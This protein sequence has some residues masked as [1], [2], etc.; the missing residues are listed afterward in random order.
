MVAMNEFGLYLKL[1]GSS[2]SEMAAAIVIY[3][4]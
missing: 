3:N 4:K 2:I 1:T